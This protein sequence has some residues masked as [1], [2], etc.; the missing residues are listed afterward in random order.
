MVHEIKLRESFAEAVI[1]R[2]KTFEVRLNDRGY[3][4]GDYIVFK[5]VTDDG[6]SPVDSILN[7]W[8]FEI[9]YV[10]SGWGIKED[11]CVFSF[12]RATYMEEVKE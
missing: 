12:R 5:V 6:L 2:E 11:Y 9:T 3:Q 1:C 8:F 7:K 4:K 10:L